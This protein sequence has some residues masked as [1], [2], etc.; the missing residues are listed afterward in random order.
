MVDNSQTIYDKPAVRVL[1]QAPKPDNY[2]HG[3]LV[4]FMDAWVNNELAPLTHDVFGEDSAQIITKKHTDGSSASIHDLRVGNDQ[5]LHVHLPPCKPGETSVPADTL[6]DI[7][8]RRVLFVMT[9]KEPGRMEWFKPKGDIEVETEAGVPVAKGEVK[10]KRY[11]MNVPP[12]TCALVEIAGGV[13]NFRN[14]RAYSY[15]PYNEPQLQPG[16]D[17]L[18][19]NT[20]A[21]KGKRP[22]DTIELVF[23][24]EKGALEHKPV[25]TD[26]VNSLQSFGKFLD[27]IDTAMC[28]LVD[29]GPQARNEDRAQFIDQVVRN[30]SPETCYGSG[31]VRESLVQG[32]GF[33]RKA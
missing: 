21:W 1:F 15:H 2:V 27:N 20:M 6:Q 30:A 22:V 12:Y 24:D 29:K 11:V 33:S 19:A 3:R 9:G 28:N 26:N 32:E 16:K 8:S 25:L 23:D 17:D 10:G 14:M 4:G 7:A 18:T 5:I 31:H 13:H